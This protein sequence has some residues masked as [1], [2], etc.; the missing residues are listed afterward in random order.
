MKTG[1]KRIH[2]SS[3]RLYSQEISCHLIDKLVFAKLRAQHAT[4]SEPSVDWSLLIK[5]VQLFAARLCIA[6]LNS[7]KLKHSA[8]I[9]YAM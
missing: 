6:Q 4:N 3:R 1:L 8:L 9:S 5:P 2:L 7:S